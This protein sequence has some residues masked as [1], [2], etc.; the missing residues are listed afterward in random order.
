MS[1]SNLEG[2][3]I[4]RSE[5]DNILDLDLVSLLSIDLYRALVFRDYRHIFSLG[6]TIVSLFILSLAIVFPISSMLLNKS[7][8]LVNNR[9]GFI[10]LL[11]SVIGFAVLLII[12]AT[13]YLWQKSLKLKSLAVLIDKLEI[14]NRL[15]EKLVEIDRIQALQTSKFTGNYTNN[16]NAIAEALHITKESLIKALSIEK[17]I[18]H[19][20]TLTSN[21]Y[22]LLIELEHNLV[23]LMSFEPESKIDEY[24]NI[25]NEVL[26]LGLGVHQ[27]VRKLNK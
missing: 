9:A 21:R 7:G 4:D 10:N 24:E 6:L 18:R 1:I 15:I 12:I 26:Q 11:F 14:Y 19:H 23:A 5:I 8:N 25:L 20:Q 22:E 2:L 16:R 17:L 3:K 27:E 13:V